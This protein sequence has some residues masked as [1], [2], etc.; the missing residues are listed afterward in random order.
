MTISQYI[1]NLS[2]KFTP[3]FGYA[4]TVSFAIV[5]IVAILSFI[6]FKVAG[7]KDEK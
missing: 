6:Q 4:A 5:V 1:Y 7:D 3:N 2:F